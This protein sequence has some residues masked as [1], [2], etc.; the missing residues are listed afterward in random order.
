MR[1]E[2]RP[3]LRFRRTIPSTRDRHFLIPTVNLAII[4]NLSTEHSPLPWFTD[5]MQT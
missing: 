2:S 4:I 5:L 1:T 3:N